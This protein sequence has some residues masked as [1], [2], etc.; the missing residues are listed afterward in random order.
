M[1][2]TA[3]IVCWLSAMLGT[4]PFFEYNSPILIG[5]TFRGKTI[6]SNV[7]LLVAVSVM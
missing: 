7:L 6:A 3:R 4:E 2:P 5:G 1:Y